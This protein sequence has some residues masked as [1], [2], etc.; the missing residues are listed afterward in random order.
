MKGAH[1]IARESVAKLNERANTCAMIVRSQAGSATILCVHRGV[2][3]LLIFGRISTNDVGQYIRF[4]TVA[5]AFVSEVAEWADVLHCVSDVDD[6]LDVDVKLLRQ[7][8]GQKLIQ[9][10]R[11]V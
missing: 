9:I 11:K 5:G 1:K 7:M 6:M 10:E 2:T 8:E 3:M 4:G